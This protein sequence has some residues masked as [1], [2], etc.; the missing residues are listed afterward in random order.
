MIH[1]LHEVIGRAACTGERK[2]E[3]KAAACAKQ[4]RPKLRN[5]ARLQSLHASLG[6]GD[7][8]VGDPEDCPIGLV[9]QAFDFPA[10]RENDLLDDG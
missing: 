6:A 10:V 8:E 7:L 4:D 9:G 5:T 2:K 1:D 3:A